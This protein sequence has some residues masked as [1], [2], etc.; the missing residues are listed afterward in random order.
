M[1]AML[2]P[3]IMCK[4]KTTCSM[5]FAVENTRSW[6]S[7]RMMLMVWSNPLSV[8]TK[9]RPSD[10][11]IDTVL[12]TYASNADAIAIFCMFRLFGIQFTEKYE[13]F[14]ENL[15]IFRR[16]P[17]TY[18][19]LVDSGFYSPKMMPKNAATF[20]NDSRFRLFSFSFFVNRI[21]FWGYVL[22]RIKMNELNWRLMRK[23]AYSHNDIASILWLFSYY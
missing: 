10:V 9:F 20:S 19:Q 12:F 8:P 3:R 2:S 6:D 14:V 7:S 15:L 11:M 23:K 5:P 1:T 17:L 22:R 4:P 21:Y 18:R 16:N 13:M